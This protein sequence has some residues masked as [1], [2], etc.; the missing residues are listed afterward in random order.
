MP[1]GVLRALAEAADFAGNTGDHTMNQRK[2]LV[3]SEWNQM[4]LVV[5][6]NVLPLSIN[7]DRAVVGNQDMARTRFGR[8]DQ[9]PPFDDAGK[10]RMVKTNRE[11]RGALGKSWVLER[12]RR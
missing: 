12:K 6:E 7:Q 1:D 10:E 11:H 9:R 5:R 2:R 4:N 8:I 3:L